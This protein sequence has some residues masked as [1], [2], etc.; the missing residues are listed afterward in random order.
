[1]KNIEVVPR[2]PIED[3]IDAV[4]R[5][6][7]NVWMDENNCERG[8]NA[9]TSYHKDYDAKNET[10]RKQPKHD[11]A[12][13]GADA[14]RYLWVVYNSLTKQKNEAITYEADYSQFY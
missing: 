11:W 12:S 13:N 3:W 2:L 6:F 1:M 10:Y 7:K 4:R 9:L 5:M 14:F 8:I